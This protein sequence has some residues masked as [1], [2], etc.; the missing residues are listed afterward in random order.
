V[1][2]AG[3]CEAKYVSPFG[4]SLLHKDIYSVITADDKLRGVICRRQAMK[5]A[6]C[7]GRFLNSIYVRG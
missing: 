1:I 2:H 7:D 4:S 5:C 6:E 3:M